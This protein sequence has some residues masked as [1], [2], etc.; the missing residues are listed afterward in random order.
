[1]PA[2]RLQRI[3]DP[4]ILKFITPT[5]LL[6]FLTSFRSYLEGRGF[7]WPISDSAQID[8]DTLSR[9]LL[10]ADDSLPPKIVRTLLF[11]DE[12]RVT[13]A[14]ISCSQ[15]APR[16]G[17]PWTSVQNARLPMSQFRRRGKPQ[18]SWRDN[19]PTHTLCDR[20]TFTTF[21]ALTASEGDFPL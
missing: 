7:R 10:S 15:R 21:P 9:I 6:Q 14:W 19:T 13:I 4:A 17:L 12:S 18:R 5:R 8:Y 16:R 20:R 2:F 3:S 11:V 1:M